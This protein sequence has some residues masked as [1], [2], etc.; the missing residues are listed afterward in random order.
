M[1]CFKPTSSGFTAPPFPPTPPSLC[2][3][4]SLS[5]C[6]PL[7]LIYYEWIDLLC[8]LVVHVMSEVRY[9]GFGPQHVPKVHTVSLTHTLSTR[10]THTC[11]RGWRVHGRQDVRCVPL[12]EDTVNNSCSQ[13]RTHTQSLFSLNSSSYLNASIAHRLCDEP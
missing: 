13:T 10:A 11:T 1:K 2:F 5:V 9:R 12:P 4:F 7:S 3:F 6:L 8:M